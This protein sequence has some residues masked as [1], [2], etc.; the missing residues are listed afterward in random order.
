MRRD[1]F[2]AGLHAYEAMPWGE[3]RERFGSPVEESGTWF[4]RKVVNKMRTT[5]GT[6][7]PIPTAYGDFVGDLVVQAP[8]RT[9]LVEFDG[10][11]FHLDRE[12]DDLRTAAILHTGLVDQVVRFPGSLIHHCPGDAAFFLS[13]VHPEATGSH[14]QHV[15]LSLASPEARAAWVD[16]AP[17][18]AAVFQ[19]N[20]ATEWEEGSWGSSVVTDRRDFYVIV[21]RPNCPGRVGR[22]LQII[23]RERPA[24]RAALLKRYQAET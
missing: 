5:L 3:R 9:T 1:D 21:D 15:G 13:R 22:M 17:D 8:G 24:T 20:A 19:Y 14:G 10:Q 18:A 11:R 7:V 2:E 12:A 6:N 4:I 16:I 23:E